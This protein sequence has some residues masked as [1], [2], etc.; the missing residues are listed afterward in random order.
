MSEQDKSQ[1]QTR[2]TSDIDNLEATELDEEDLEDVS[3]GDNSGCNFN[4]NKD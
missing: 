1:E 2:K 3:G 4:N